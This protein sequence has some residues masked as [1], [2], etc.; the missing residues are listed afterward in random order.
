MTGI[1]KTGV[2]KTE[3]EKTGIEKTGTEKNERKL[4]EHLLVR[5]AKI[6]DCTEGLSR[7]WDPAEAL[8]RD[9]CSLDPEEESL[10]NAFQTIERRL[11]ELISDFRDVNVLGIGRAAVLEGKFMETPTES[12]QLMSM[13][14]QSLRVVIAQEYDSFARDDLIKAGIVP[15]LMDE[16]IY[17]MK[18]GDWLLL[19]DIAGGLLERRDKVMGFLV[20][21]EELSILW[22][23]AGLLKDEDLRMLV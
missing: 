2:E 14:E 12:E 18:D 20:E 10:R 16:G 23:T 7:G 3:I 9:A 13:K 21:G 11:P 1:N 22:M 8:S 19:P 17:S 5:I 4:P 6:Q 15:L